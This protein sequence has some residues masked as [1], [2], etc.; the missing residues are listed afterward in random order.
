M[1]EM[2]IN[3]A[4]WAISAQLRQTRRKL[5]RDGAMNTKYQVN[6]SKLEIVDMDKT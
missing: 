2:I 3:C 5:A 4:E 1:G 6:S